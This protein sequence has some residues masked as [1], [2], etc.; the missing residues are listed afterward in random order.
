M[1]PHLLVELAKDLV[2]SGVD[3]VSRVIAFHVHL[4][5]RAQHALVLQHELVLPAKRRR[6]L[7]VFF[8][9]VM[10]PSFVGR[11]GRASRAPMIYD[12]FVHFTDDGVALRVGLACVVIR[13]VI[14]AWGARDALVV[15]HELVFST[16]GGD[17]LGVSLGSRVAG[18][19]RCTRRALLALV[20][21]HE[22]VDLAERD[23]ARRVLL[24]GV[25]AR[26]VRA[27]RCAL[28]AFM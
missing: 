22:L 15:L 20:V 23:V 21:A 2:A 18:G 24:R 19:S 14:H 26:G 8:G 11:A 13:R 17:A 27:A 25:V 10:P 3:V 1:V 5:R 6:A 12:F 16:Q 7:S 9:R 4:A 28:L